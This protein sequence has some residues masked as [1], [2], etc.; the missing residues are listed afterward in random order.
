MNND[1]KLLEEAY[2]QVLGEG[3]KSSS[4]MDIM[5]KIQKSVGTLKGLRGMA[6]GMFAFLDFEDGQ[7]YEIQIRPIDYGKYKY[8]HD[9]EMKQ[10]LEQVPE[11]E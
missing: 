3:L 1:V 7:T 11:Q 9:E 4:I 5:S 8:F 2:Q 10:K 6:D